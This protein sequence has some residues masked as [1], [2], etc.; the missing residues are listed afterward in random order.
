MIAIHHRKG[1]FSERWIEYCE[2]NKIVYKI[3][4]C[5]DNDILKILTD[6]EYL[7]WHWSHNNNQDLKFARQI[8][9]AI[10]NQ[11]KKVFPNI[12]TCWHFDDKVAQKYLLEAINA[13]IVPSFVFYDKESAY[14]WIDNTSFPKVFKLKGGAGSMNV[15]LVHSK[16]EAKSKVNKAFTSGFST[17]NQKQ[18]LK[19]K[20]NIFKNDINVNNAV[21]VLKRT[22]RLFIKNKQELSSDKEKGYIYFQEF[23]PENLFDIRVIVIGNKIFAIKRMCREGDFRA[24]GSGVIVYDKNEIDIDC[25]KIAVKT[26][27]Q[28]DV[29]CLAYDFIFDQNNTPLIVEM[30]YGFSM[31]GYDDC[32]GYWDENLYW[33]EKKFI[34]QYWMVENLITKNMRNKRCM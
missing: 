18:L 24:S 23:I 6:C 32:P 14:A 15:E 8:I 4:N 2:K 1:S 28:L 16:N 34:P 12:K 25:I 17:I 3:V 10:E 31:E 22:V 21:E 19:D 20:I 33:H 11:G 7:M 5:F 29:Q 27:K 9:Q 26:S 13:P 30:S